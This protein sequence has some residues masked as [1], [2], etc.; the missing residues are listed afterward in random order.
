MADDEARFLAGV[1]L[2]VEQADLGYPRNTS[3]ASTLH[4]R[5]PSQ[6]NDN[7]DSLYLGYRRRLM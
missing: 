6:S 3:S 2:G 7:R 4:C 5:V 1:R